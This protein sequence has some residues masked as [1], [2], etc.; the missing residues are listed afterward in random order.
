MWNWLYECY[1]DGSLTMHDLEKVM[2]DDGAA[3]ILWADW[4]IDSNDFIEYVR[5]EV[6]PFIHHL[7]KKEDKK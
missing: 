3:R 2:V 6:F 1:K 4:T 5:S 7:K